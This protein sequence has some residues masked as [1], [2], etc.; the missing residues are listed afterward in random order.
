[1]DQIPAGRAPPRNEPYRL[2]QLIPHGI[3]NAAG[4]SPFYSL[5]DEQLQGVR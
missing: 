3:Q 5:A 1:M 2:L 4:I